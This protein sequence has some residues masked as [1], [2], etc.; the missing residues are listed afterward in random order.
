MGEPP[1]SD[2]ASPPRLTSPSENCWRAQLPLGA[3]VSPCA[4]T[5]RSLPK[6]RLLDL[7]SGDG[8]Y[9]P[10]SCRSQGHPLRAAPP[11]RGVGW[12]AASREST[13]DSAHREESPPDGTAR[14]PSTLKG[15]QWTPALQT[16]EGALW[17]A[18]WGCDPILPQRLGPEAGAG[19]CG[20]GLEGGR[21]T[22]AQRRAWD[23]Q[24]SLEAAPDTK[25]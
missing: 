8:A 21:E 14:P 4:K 22:G 13:Q 12:A 15:G 10:P 23:P 5:G 7:L 20:Q 25:G 3:R 16:T 24:V 6:A 18:R 11:L 17:G 1:S 19:G 9:S 2:S